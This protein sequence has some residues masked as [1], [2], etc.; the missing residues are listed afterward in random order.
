MS[1]VEKGTTEDVWIGEE[2]VENDDVVAE[3]GMTDAVTMSDED[4]NDDVLAEDKT[5][6]LILILALSSDL[7]CGLLYL[8]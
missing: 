4:V 7:S 8:L 6:F 5:E 3:K 2:A 1:D